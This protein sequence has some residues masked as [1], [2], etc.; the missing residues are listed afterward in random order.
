MRQ[1]HT[2][3]TPHWQAYFIGTRRGTRACIDNEKFVTGENSD[4]LLRARAIAHGRCR[5]AKSNFQIVTA[6]VIDKARG[7]IILHADGDQTVL[8]GFAVAQSHKCGH[9]QNKD[10]RPEP[11]KELNVFR[12]IFCS[13]RLK[14]DK[15]HYDI[16][17]VITKQRTVV[18]RAYF[19]FG[20][21]LRQASSN[22]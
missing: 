13:V 20:S 17:N 22:P 10:T 15:V 9:N 12:N 2:T 16:N 19:N 7:D 4:A 1:Q 3:Q 5:A 14:I 6:P 11:S 21:I 8:Q 18:T